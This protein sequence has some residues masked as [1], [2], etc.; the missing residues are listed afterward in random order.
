MEFRRMQPDILAKSLSY[1]PF[2]EVTSMCS[3]EK[4]LNSFC[5]NS[6]GRYDRQWRNMIEDTFGNTYDYQAKLIE[7]NHKLGYNGIR[8]NYVVYTNLVKSLDPV[9]QLMIYNRQGDDTFYSKEFSDTERF[10]ALYLLGRYEESKKYVT[11]KVF[12]SYMRLLTGDITPRE[13]RILMITNSSEGYL[14][15]VKFLASKGA[16]VNLMRP[17]VKGDVKVV[18]LLLDLG[19]DPTP[20]LGVAVEFGRSDTVRLLLDR[21]AIPTDKNLKIAKSR[22]S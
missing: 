12:D 19:A 9:T 10:I 13:L 1:L 2:E 5:Q 17:A 6:D 15:M 7:L 4:A 3:T 20:M 11:D 14:P 21:G 18:K 22:I 16:D 8:Y